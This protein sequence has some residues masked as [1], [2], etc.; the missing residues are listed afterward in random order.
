MLGF[1]HSK[2]NMS[3]YNLPTLFACFSQTTHPTQFLQQHSPAS[4][5]MS[6]THPSKGKSKAKFKDAE[7]PEGYSPSKCSLADFIGINEDSDDDTE[8]D[9]DSNCPP[10]TRLKTSEEVNKDSYFGVDGADNSGSGS[11]NGGGSGGKNGSGSWLVKLQGTCQHEY[12]LFY[13]QH[14]YLQVRS[15]TALIHQCMHRNECHI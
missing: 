3:P 4:H 14:H 5:T 12:F 1:S 10:T 13:F 2:R 11:K 6:D 9:I 8:D 7:S 15:N